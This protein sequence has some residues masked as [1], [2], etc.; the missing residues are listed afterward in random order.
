[1]GFTVEEA[2]DISKLS[3]LN[4]TQA[5]ST[6]DTVNNQVIALGKQQGIYLDNRKVTADVAKISGQLSAQ[7]K[8]NPELLAKAVI[9]T[10]KIGTNLQDAANAASSLLK[11]ETSIES[12]L[13]AELLTG[14][15]LNLEKAR[16]LALRGDAAGAAKELR[17]QIGSLT[18]F[19]NLNVI[20]QQAL[21]E[22]VGTT[23]DKLA[24]QLKM[25]E[26]LVQTGD[27][28]V[29]ALNE[30]RKTMI[31]SGQEQEFYAELQR[32]NTSDELIAQQQELGM[33]DKINMLVEKLLETFSSLAEGPLNLIN[34]LFTYIT[35]HATAFKIITASLVGLMA[36][37][38][39]SS[40]VLGVTQYT[41][42]NRQ[43]AIQTALLRAQVP[44][45]NAIGTAEAKRAAYAI[46]ATEASTGGL[47]TPA[48]IGGIAAVAAFA[49]LSGF[50]SGGGSGGGLGDYQSQTN[51]GGRA[52]AEKHITVNT[53]STLTI[54]N[55]E[56]TK[57]STNQQKLTP[58][59]LR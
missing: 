23:A 12:E 19:Q 20:Q 37:K 16:E 9:E 6:L 34:R 47:A 54:G 28:N 11:F 45:L 31:A 33:Q 51:N 46:T 59:P 5:K 22:A 32:A 10:A 42:M 58:G 13:K 44:V 35:Q 38:F 24:D 3:I 41:L 21:A 14:K 39:V 4:G 1:M 17:N 57:L 36:G 49:G 2:T 8:N 55:S 56:T 29:A 25:E 40:L 50:F 7:Y 48:I 15:A 53:Y 26:L 52:E 27:K 18:D 30:R 43:I